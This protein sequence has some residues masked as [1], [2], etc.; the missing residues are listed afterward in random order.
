MLVPSHTSTKSANWTVT[1]PSDVTM[2]QNATEMKTKME[3]APKKFEQN[4]MNSVTVRNNDGSKSLCCYLQ[5]KSNLSD[6]P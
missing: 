3:A 2:T 6:V 1:I 4:K 5:Q